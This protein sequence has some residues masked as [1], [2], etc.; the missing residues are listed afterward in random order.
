MK[1]TVSEKCFLSFWGFFVIAF[2]F[3]LFFFLHLDKDQKQ[4]MDWNLA[5]DVTNYREFQNKSD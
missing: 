2:C 1:E 4:G 3:V 5:C